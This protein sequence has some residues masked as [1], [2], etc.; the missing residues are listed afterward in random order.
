MN[1]SAIFCFTVIKKVGRESIFEIIA[2]ATAVAKSTHQ[3][4]KFVVYLEAD[5]ARPIASTLPTNWKEQGHEGTLSLVDL[6]QV[7]KLLHNKRTSEQI[8][9]SQ[10][11]HTSYKPQQ[12]LSTNTLVIVIGCRAF[13]AAMARIHM[14]EIVS[15]RVKLID[16]LTGLCG[17]NFYSKSTNV[18]NEN[19]LLAS[20]RA[21]EKD[22]V[23]YNLNWMAEHVV[24]LAERPSHESVMRRLR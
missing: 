10:P 5:R 3:F 11:G 1:M 20:V 9:R 7:Q 24:R 2:N 19:F 21:D 8:A 12:L 15:L 18:G 6:H 17:L 4:N 23:T 13:C 16:I 22:Y 14:E